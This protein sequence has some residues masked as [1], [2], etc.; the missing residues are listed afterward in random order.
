MFNFRAPCDILLLFYAILT[1]SKKFL[2][3]PFQNFSIYTMMVY[4]E[5][6]WKMTIWHKIVIKHARGS[7]IK[8]TL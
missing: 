2:Y 7:K 5:N 3:I 1:F 6:F 4:I 8:H